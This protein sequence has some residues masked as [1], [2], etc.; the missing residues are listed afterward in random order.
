MSKKS[1]SK[2]ADKVGITFEVKGNVRQL[3][4]VRM[5]QPMPDGWYWS[6]DNPNGYSFC[7]GPF[8]DCI[9]AGF[10]MYRNASSA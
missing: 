3:D 7:H 9:T 5:P 8:S 4:G 2:N 1:K 6:Y 10:D